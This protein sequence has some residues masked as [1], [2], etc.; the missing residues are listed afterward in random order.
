MPQP[1]QP[2]IENKIQLFGL[3]TVKAGTRIS[4][5]HK[6]NTVNT[7]KVVPL[8]SEITITYLNSYSC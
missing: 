8:V 4:M 5:G 6:K 3:P 7:V 1:G 2:S